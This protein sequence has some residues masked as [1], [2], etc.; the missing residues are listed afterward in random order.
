MNCAIILTLIF[1]AILQYSAKLLKK[2][3]QCR[4]V[5]ACS[6]LFWVNEQDGVKD[7]ERCI[8]IYTLT[9]YSSY[10]SILSMGCTSDGNL[11]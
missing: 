6:H 4:A 7:G 1:F 8:V 9:V 10:Q 3:D 2:P 5:Y 11:S